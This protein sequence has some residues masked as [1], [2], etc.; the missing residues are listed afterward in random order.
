MPN[1]SGQYSNTYDLKNPD[2]FVAKNTFSKIKELRASTIIQCKNYSHLVKSVR[3]D[4]HHEARHDKERSQGRADNHKVSAVRLSR[5]RLSLDPVD[6][7]ALVL[8]L[9]RALLGTLSRFSAVTPLPLES[10]PVVVI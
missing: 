6:L 7:A 5:D 10:V 2:T 8:V 9:R 1:I 4:A 3:Q